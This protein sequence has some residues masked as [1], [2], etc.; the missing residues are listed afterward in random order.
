[1]VHTVSAESSARGDAA[2]PERYGTAAAAT[3]GGGCPD[4]EGHLCPPNGVGALAGKNKTEYKVRDTEARRVENS[5]R[6]KEQ[7]GDSMKRKWYENVTFFY[8]VFLCRAPVL[9][10]LPVSQAAQR[11]GRLAGPGAP[12]GPRGPAAPPGPQRWVRRGRVPAS[13]VPLTSPAP[14][15]RRTRPA[16]RRAGHMTS[17]A[18]RAGRVT[19]LATTGWRHRSRGRPH[20]ALRVSLASLRPSI[21][22]AA[23]RPPP[24]LQ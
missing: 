20:S 13:A 18:H 9:V 15:D 21:P 7:Q 16:S 10:A 23:L 8:C 3:G 6:E 19:S 5:Q 17:L 4:G 14:P 22:P 24:V 2:P 12:V 1:M 11:P